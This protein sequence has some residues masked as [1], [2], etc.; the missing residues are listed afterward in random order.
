LCVSQRCKEFNRDSEQNRER[1]CYLPTIDKVSSLHLQ[2]GF[3]EYFGAALLLGRK[4]FGG[5]AVKGCGGK[6][7]V[8]FA[9]DFDCLRQRVVWFD[10]VEFDLGIRRFECAG[11]VAGIVEWDEFLRRF[12]FVEAFVSLRAGAR[13][14]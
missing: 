2:G 6:L 9:G 14:R 8:G 13:G 3:D 7:R 11:G 1:G 12:R 4:G 5:Y 10:P